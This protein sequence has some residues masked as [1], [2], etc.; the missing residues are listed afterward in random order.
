MFPDVVS[1]FDA[2]VVPRPGLLYIPVLYLHFFH[3]LGGGVV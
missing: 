3:S 1:D 2:E